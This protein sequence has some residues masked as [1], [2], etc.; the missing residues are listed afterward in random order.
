MEDRGL[1][2]SPDQALSYPM[3]VKLRAANV[4]RQILMNKV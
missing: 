2:A 4:F 3:G 1:V